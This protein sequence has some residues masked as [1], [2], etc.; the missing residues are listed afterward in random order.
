MSLFWA[1]PNPNF[2]KSTRSQSE[3]QQIMVDMEQQHW[4]LMLRL[5]FNDNADS[6]LSCLSAKLS[7][8]WSADM[9]Y[10]VHNKIVNIKYC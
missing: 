8:I 2:W 7:R 1:T 6:P 3:Q 9:T 4:K 5:L 10:Y